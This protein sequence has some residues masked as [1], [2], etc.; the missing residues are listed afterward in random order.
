MTRYM[1]LPFEVVAEMGI[2]APL[3]MVKA[4]V[5]MKSW[6]ERFLQSVLRM[7]VL[8][9]L[10]MKTDV[11]VAHDTMVKDGLN[12]VLTSSQCLA[13]VQNGDRMDFLLHEAMRPKLVT[14]TELP[15]KQALVKPETVLTPRQGRRVRALVPKRRPWKDKVSRNGMQAKMRRQM[16]IIHLTGALTRV[17]QK[18]YVAA[19]TAHFQVMKERV[20]RMRKKDELDLVEEHILPRIPDVL[21]PVDL[22]VGDIDPGGTK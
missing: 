22:P 21:V 2:V 5:Q 7:L 8:G 13:L 1:G 19:A 9:S 14:T 17:L 15:R 10:P 6:H 16:N 11:L 4:S 3:G 20:E 12:L 18:Q